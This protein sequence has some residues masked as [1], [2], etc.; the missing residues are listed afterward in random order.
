M[1][2]RNYSSRSQQTTLTSAVTAGASS[3]VVVSGAA[4]LGG[5]SIPGGTT[6]TIVLDPDTAIEEIVDATAVGGNTFTIT[7]AIDGSSAQA[8]SAGAVV[9]HMAIGRD[10]RESNQHIEATTAVHG[11]GVSSAV[12]GTTDTQTL[13]NKTLT[14]PTI[15]NPNISGAGVDASIVFEGATPDAFETTLT[16]VDPTQDNTVTIPNTTGTVVI[17]TAA[18]TLTNKTLTSPTI[19]GSPVI[20][21]LS[22]AG[23]SAS[24]ATPKDYVDS[25]LGSATAAATSAASAATSATSAATSATS[26]E[27]SAVA[28]ATSATASATSATAAATSATSAAASATAAATSATSAA[29]SATAAATSATSANASAI[30]AAASVATISGFATAASNSASAAATSATS[31]AASVTAAA[32]SASSA[33]TSASAAATS[34]SSASTSASS[35]LT[36]ANS[37]AVSAASAAAAVTTAIQASIID[38]KGDLIVGT[39]AD[40]AGRLAIGTNGYILTADSAETTGIKWSAAPAGYLAPTIGTT[41]I[42]S[43][44]TVSTVESV[45]L[46]NATVTG[47]LTAGATSGTNGYLL[48]ATTS[49][50]TWAAA[51]VSLPSQTGNTGKLLTTDGTTASWSGAAPIASPTEPTTL[52][53]GLIWVDTDGTAP[54]TVVTRWTEQPTAGTTVLTGNDDY[55][56]PLAYSPGYEQ[57]FLN[58]VLLSRSGS[59]Y[60][61]TNGTSIT[62]ASATVAGDIVEV[63]CPL[64]IATTDTYTQSAVNNAFQANTNNFAAGKNHLING[65]FNIWQRGTSF[66]GITDTYTADRWK[67]ESNR[68]GSAVSQQTFTPGTAPV[69]G[70]EGAFYLRYTPGTGG[71]YSSLIQRIEDVRTFANTTVT[72]S[73][74]AKCSTGTITNEPY[75]FQNFGSG[76]SSEVQTALATSTITTSWQRFTQSF[77]IPSISG[78]TIGTSSYL[79]LLLIRPSAAT[80]TTIDVWGVQLEAGSNA[81]AFQTATGTIQGELAACQRYYYRSSSADSQYQTHA[82][83]FC[84][85]S[86]NAMVFHRVPVTMR[87]APTSLEYGSLLLVDAAFGGGGTQTLTFTSTENSSN[88]VQI[89]TSNATGLTAYRPVYLRNNNTTA[90]Y[91]AFSAEL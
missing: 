40:T 27:A 71:A 68:T 60:T 79:S 69:A 85:S 89:M 66:S 16:V 77:T 7:R 80:S 25:I 17:A 78:K 44:T 41:V 35:A 10:Y 87:V 59:E 36:S 47:T 9:R 57:V 13:T 39:A 6:F 62:L 12:V 48:T 4:L 82:T 90:G 14:S 20:T 84:W 53:D 50:V 56:I 63:I 21:G 23:M 34:A 15:T 8:H 37:A 32:T 2:T 19:S 1:T 76:G 58:G 83:G 52:I 75:Y 30:T 72:L 70:Y 42:T 86:T 26:A 3:M 22:S 88:M 54:T 38:A 64:Q 28:S 73:Y 49:G 24:S 45:T 18:Q 5:Q 67:V 31:A 81:T 51:P 91:I 61:A 55:S 43:G 33:S 46:N 65:D 74:W 29:V 11:L